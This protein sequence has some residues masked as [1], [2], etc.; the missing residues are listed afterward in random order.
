MGDASGHVYLHEDGWTDA[1]NTRVGNI[2]LESGALGVLTSVGDVNQMLLA[3][4]K[5]FDAISTEFFAQLTPQDETEYLFGPY[6]T[7]PDGWTDAR[8]TGRA[9]RIRF[10]ATR[11]A[12]WSIGKIQ[13]DVSMGGS[14][15]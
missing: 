8:V 10:A 6:Y 11:D 12:G 9:A 2:W 5:G 4:G 3:G 1:G 7:R 13:L 15:R 14:G